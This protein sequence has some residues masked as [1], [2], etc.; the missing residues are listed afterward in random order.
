MDT[1]NIDVNTSMCVFWDFELQNGVGDWST[2]GCIFVG[3]ENDRVVCQC[4][5][6]TN[7]AVLMVNNDIIL[8]DTIHF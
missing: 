7:F 1:T 8:I 2:E 4:N 6:L 3:I 5:H